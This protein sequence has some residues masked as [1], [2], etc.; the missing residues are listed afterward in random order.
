M[1][2]IYLQKED[3]VSAAKEFKA[4]LAADPKGFKAAYNYAYAIETKTPDD[5]TANIANWQDFVRVAGANPKAKEDVA[6]ATQHIKELKEAQK[7]KGK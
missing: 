5:Y 1:G 7:A 2:Q 4:A 6:V 3:Y